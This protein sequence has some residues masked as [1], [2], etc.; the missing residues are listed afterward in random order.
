MRGTTRALTFGFL[1]FA[2]LFGLGGAMAAD[3]P[4]ASDSD[5]TLGATVSSDA[6][7]ISAFQITN[8]ADTNL[9][10]GQLDVQTTYYFN[11]TV[12]DAN[13]WSDI[14]WINL[15]IW[16]DGG[17]EVTFGSQTTGANYRSDLNY[18]NVAPLTDPALSEW[19]VAEGNIVYNSTDSQSFTNT[20]NQN[21]TF[22]LSFQLNAQMRQANDPVNSGT[23]NYDDPNSWNAEVRAKDVDNPDVINRTNATGVYH[24]FGIFQFTSVS[25]A[26]NWDAGTIAPGASGTSTAVAV[27][28][29][30]NRAYDLKVWFDTHLTSGANTID[31]SNI[32]ITAAGDTNDDVLA[33]TAFAGL[34][35]TNA[36]IIRNDTSN[37]THEVSAN[38]ATTNVQFRVFVPFGTASGSYTANLTIKVE[39]P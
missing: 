3:I 20:A 23:S 37:G 12:N 16:F 24:E 5:N 38:S 14:Q 30:S 8:A 11:V 32:N 36:L 27:T 29:R 7:V 13:G 15:R 39:Q 9:M 31:V 17:T 26:S 28:H 22:K 1:T 19:S 35:E 10:H 18:T 33:D 4:S 25:I 6:P 2:L 21:Y 34:T